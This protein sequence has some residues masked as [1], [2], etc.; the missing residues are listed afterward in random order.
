M[1]GVDED[2]ELRVLVVMEELP[3]VRRV[4]EMPSTGSPSVATAQHHHHH[5]H[6]HGLRVIIAATKTADGYGLGAG[7]AAPFRPPSGC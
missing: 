3:S 4:T 7:L 5:H 1:E 6:R 2:P